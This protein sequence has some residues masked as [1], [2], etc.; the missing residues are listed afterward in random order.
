MA[1]FQPFD[2]ETNYAQTGRH[3]LTLQCQAGDHVDTAGAAHVDLAFFFRVGVDQDFGLKPVGLQA[4]GAVHAD[5]FS[6]GQQHLQRAVNHAVIGQHRQR[7]G[8][9]DAVIG[10]QG[11]ATCFHPVAIDIGLNGIAGKIVVGVVILLRNHVQVR[12]QHH[13][14]AFFHAAAGRF[15]QQ[16]VA[17][18]VALGV[19]PFWLA[20][21]MRWAASASS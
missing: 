5:L 10:T 2:T 6:H 12:L 16:N 1:A 20:H 19:D 8:H 14:N 4:E 13:R 11:G 3:R 21:A 15:T 17:Y 9:A 18:S 7:R